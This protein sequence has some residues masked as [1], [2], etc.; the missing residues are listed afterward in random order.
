MSVVNTDWL[1]DIGDFM[2]EDVSCIKTLE[3]DKNLPW[4]SVFFL[5]FTW[6]CEGET[7]HNNMENDFKLHY[8]VCLVLKKYQIK[9][10]T[11]L[12]DFVEGLYNSDDVTKIRNL[13][14]LL[15][16]L[17]GNR[18]LNH[19][20][21]DNIHRIGSENFIFMDRLTQKVFGVNDEFVVYEIV[22]EEVWNSNDVLYLEKSKKRKF[23]KEI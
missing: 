22:W 16:F 23:V 13:F 19:E 3:L 10:Q 15:R 2:E 8:C 21:I 20:S 6:L 4:E 12:G 18:D 17:F 9:M 5:D 11:M 14:I 7:N 1:D